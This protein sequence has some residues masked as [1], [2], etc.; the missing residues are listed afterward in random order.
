MGRYRIIGDSCMDLTELM[1]EDKEAFST[2]P[3]TLEL[4]G[5]SI[6]DDENFDQA[7]FLELMKKSSKGPATACPSPGDFLKAYECDADDIYVVTITAKLS[8][9]Y[10]AAC[11]ARDMYFEHHGHDK[12]IAV[13]NSKSGC[14]GETRMGLYIKDLCDKG[15]SFKEIEE[16]AVKK[17][18]DLKTFFVL[19][20]MET[21]RKTGRLSGTAAR[22][23]TLLNIK[24]ILFADNGEIK[25]FDTARSIERSLK[26]MC[27]IC[28]E[29]A[30]AVAD[31]P[32]R[33]AIVHCNCPE[34]AESVKAY[35][36]GLAEFVSIDIAQARGVSTIYASDGGIVLAI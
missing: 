20:N 36:S 21:L 12:N 33:A 10:N 24:P 5:L 32:L 4:D 3:L 27:D 11:I 15:L 25:K 23:A 30:K 22:F 7:S 6:K 28:V 35:L 18:D 17:A 13:I 16:K 34:R 1:A 9:T 8:G 2:V 19:Q 26:K 14:A 29:Q 31:G